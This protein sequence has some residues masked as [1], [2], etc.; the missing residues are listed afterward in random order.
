MLSQRRSC[1]ALDYHAAELDQVSSGQ[2]PDNCWSTMVSIKDNRLAD[3]QLVL[4][5][6]IDVD[7][8]TV[9]MVNHGCGQLV[10]VNNHRDIATTVVGK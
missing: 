10:H 2:Q 6:M 5:T 1:S 9:T 4:V 3:N 8:P 7:K